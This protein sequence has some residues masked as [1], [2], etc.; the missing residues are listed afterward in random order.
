MFQPFICQFNRR[1]I[2]YE[3]TSS[4][5]SIVRGKYFEPFTTI[6]RNNCNANTREYFDGITY[7]LQANCAI[8]ANTE[9]T[10]RF[11]YIND[12]KIRH[13]QFME[14]DKLDCKCNLCIR[15]NL[16]PIGDLRERMLSVHIYDHEPGVNK[17]QLTK[18]LTID[19]KVVTDLSYNGFGYD[20]PGLRSVYMSIFSDQFDLDSR[21]KTLDYKESLRLLLTVY[22]FID[23]SC[24]PGTTTGRAHQSFLSPQVQKTPD[25]RLAR[26]SSQCA[27][28]S[29]IGVRSSFTTPNK[30][31]APIPKLP[32]FIEV[33]SRKI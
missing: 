26:S 28:L 2:S 16:G 14:T 10:R 6:M 9:I 20:C 11:S 27:N 22:Y 18:Q 21:T 31:V 25:P 19:K 17:E 15:G 12:Y 3:N 33:L 32:H 24:M 5:R 8:P 13:L 1:D 23:H 7:I 30:W 29:I 4:L